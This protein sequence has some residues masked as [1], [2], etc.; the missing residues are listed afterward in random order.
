MQTGPAGR[1]LRLGC[2]T[3]RAPPAAAAAEPPVSVRACMRACVCMCTCA[4]LYQCVYV[5]VCVR[6]CEPIGRLGKGG[7]SNTCVCA[8]LCG[9]QAE[10]GPAPSS[11]SLHCPGVMCAAEES[12]RL[13]RQQQQQMRS[14]SLGQGSDWSLW[15]ASIPGAAKSPHHFASPSSCFGTHTYHTH[16]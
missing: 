4:C 11:C 1:R 15:P 10:G 13:Q 7:M 6:E 5:N 16:T 3:Q 8:V 12:S 14:M 9:V 2:W